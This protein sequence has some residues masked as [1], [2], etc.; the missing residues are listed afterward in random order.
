MTTITVQMNQQLHWLQRK[1]TLIQHPMY[2]IQLHYQR[3]LKY[4]LLYWL[5]WL[6]MIQMHHA[7]QWFL[8]RGECKVI[9]LMRAWKWSYHS[10][11]RRHHHFTFNWDC[12]WWWWLLLSISSTSSPSSSSSSSTPSSYLHG[13]NSI[14]ITT[15]MKWRWWWWQ[16]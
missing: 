13:D 9:I 14:F 1:M 10:K 3:C 15:A 12:A 7:S 4:H 11:R 5:L 6:M 2:W 16:Y 8:V